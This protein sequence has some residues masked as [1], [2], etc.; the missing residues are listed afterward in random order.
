MIIMVPALRRFVAGFISVLAMLVFASAY[1]GNGDQTAEGDSTCW[2][3]GVGADLASRY[4]WRGMMLSPGAVVQPYAEIARGGFT[5][6]VWG[7]SSLHA[8]TWMETDLY[9]SYDIKHFS[10]SL[11]DYYTYDETVNDPGFFGFKR[12]TTGHVIEAIAEFT[13]SENMPFRLLGGVNVYGA[14][15][16]NS[17]YFEIAW[18]KHLS[19][20]DIEL[21]AGYTPT[22]GYYHETKKGL[23]ILA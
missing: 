15:T 1:A 22:V 5:F 12:N 14:D 16:S 10:F 21:F 18:M 3:A 11:V 8:F 2:H 23:P 19:D 4:L 6:G 9:L 7:S 20:I 17:L 13:G